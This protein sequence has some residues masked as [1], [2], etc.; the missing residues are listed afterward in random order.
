MKKTAVWVAMA[1]LFTL[2]GCGDNNQA[3]EAVFKKSIE[4]FNQTKGVCLPL[5]LDV[6]LPDG[7]F[8]R[9]HNVLGEP[10]I[11]IAS[12]NQENKR[13]NQV[14]Q[15]QMDILID[16]GFYQKEKHWHEINIT[17]EDTSIQE[18]NQGQDVIIVIG[19]ELNKNKID[20]Y[21]K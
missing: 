12:R 8:A 3:N 20:Q 15:E 2:A 17:Q 13:I 4:R 10:L 16:E 9:V 7:Q 19:E 18:I 5:S 14:A 21:F 11:R 1:A 6:Q